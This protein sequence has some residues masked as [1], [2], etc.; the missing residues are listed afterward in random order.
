[1]LVA[2]S[3]LRMYGSMSDTMSD[4]MRGR[5][6]RYAV[7]T[8][9][10]IKYFLTDHHP[11]MEVLEELNAAIDQ[12][13]QSSYPRQGD[14]SMRQPNSLM[15]NVARKVLLKLPTELRP[16]LESLAANAQFS[17]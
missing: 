17:L 8:P 16:H 4:T 14:L 11:P 10:S 13:R 7:S 15:Q 6:V 5:A 3:L 2:A 12:V 9:V 1:M